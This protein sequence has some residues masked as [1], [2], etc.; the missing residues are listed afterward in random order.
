MASLLTEYRASPAEQ[1]RIADLFLLIPSSGTNAIDIG[2]RDCYLAQ[3]LAE[4]F[5][6]VVALDLE[7]PDVQHPGIE[8]IAGNVVSLPFGDSH[9]D[10]VLC[11]EVLEHIPEDLLVKACSEIS[12]VAKDKVVIGV[13]YRQDLRCGRTTCQNCGKSNPPWGHVN[14]FDENRLKA[15]FGTLVL[16]RVSFVGASKDSTNWLSA[17]LLDYAGNPFGTWEQE[18]PCVYCGASIGEPGERSMS[19]RLATRLA[20]I[21]NKLQSRFVKPRGNWIH[22]L[23]SKPPMRNEKLVT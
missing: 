4:R 2:A 15:L 23:F 14:S 18:E 7:S 1:H 16:E 6:K 21:L 12:R 19:Q 11:A 9:F 13:P 10:A 17:A 5:E 8:P 3:K 22:V 20:F